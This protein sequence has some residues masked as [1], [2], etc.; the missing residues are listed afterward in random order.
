MGFKMIKC[1]FKIGVIFVFLLIVGCGSKQIN[2]LGRSFG[3][4]NNPDP[5]KLG[6]KPK[7]PIKQKVPMLFSGSKLVPAIPLTSPIIRP[8]YTN[9]A[10]ANGPQ[11]RLKGKKQLNDVMVFE[12]QAFVSDFI[13]II[14]AGGAA[15][16]VWALA[17]GNWIWGYTLIN[18]KSFGD[19][20]IWQLLEF[21]K[22]YVMIKNAKTNTCLNAYGGGIVHYPCD[23]SNQAQFWKL[24][25]MS[26]QA[27]QIQNLATGKCIQTP[28]GNPLGDFF[29]IFKIFLTEC[30]KPGKSNLDQQW[31]IAAPTFTAR[32]L[33]QPRRMTK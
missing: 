13:T 17:P 5:L 18:S 4:W 11:P 2:P 12:N 31:Y 26:N 10:A 28:I 29:K 30:V 23:Q 21:P 33:Y 6:A 14:N 9:R 27:W 25:P 24:I 32:P 7:I 20:R 22:D 15:L 16:T 19:A 8:N 1:V 3:A